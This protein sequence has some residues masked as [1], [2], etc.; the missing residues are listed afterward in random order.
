MSAAFERYIGIDYSGAQTCDSSLKG[1]R[2]YMADHS[3]EPREIAPPPSPRWYWTRKTIAQCL[4]ERLSESPATLV[5]LTTAFPSRTDSRTIGGS[6]AEL[7]A[8]RPRRRGMASTNDLDCSLERFFNPSL[9]PQERKSPKSKAGFWGSL[10]GKGE[11]V[12]TTPPA[13]RVFDGRSYATA[14]SSPF[15][16]KREAAYST[17]K[18][19]RDISDRDFDDA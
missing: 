12:P 4:V 8:G 7:S 18:T 16:L 11:S 2:V 5:V 14:S 15:S 9:T 6:A 10:K 17:C 13:R 1:L 19:R 3:S